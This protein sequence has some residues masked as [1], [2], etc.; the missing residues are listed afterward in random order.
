MH[1]V[2]L[3]LTKKILHPRVLALFFMCSLMPSFCCAETQTLDTFMAPI[4]ENKI[5]KVKEAHPS[6][7]PKDIPIQAQMAFKE[8]I[9]EPGDYPYQR[10]RREAL[11][12]EIITLAP[13]HFPTWFL[14][15]HRESISLAKHKTSG[16]K[17][18]ADAY[19]RFKQRAQK[20]FVTFGEPAQRSLI[21]SCVGKGLNAPDI[22]KEAEKT[23]SLKSIKERT[24]D[25]LRLY[26]HH[27]MPYD[28][29]SYA[30]AQSGQACFKWSHPLK[31][32]MTPEDYREFITVHPHVENLDISANNNTLC[33]KGLKYGE[34]YDV[35]FKQGLP[36]KY[37][38]SLPEAKSFIVNIP[39]RSDMLSFREKGYI[40]S[41]YEKKILPLSLTNLT[42]VEAKLYHIPN[43]NI[44]PVLQSHGGLK[45]QIQYWHENDF[46]NTTGNFVWEGQIDLDND[47]NNIQTIGLPL[48]QMG[49]D[50]EKPGL[51]VLQAHEKDDI[52]H[53]WNKESSTQWFIVT[54]LAMI[55]LKG[56]DGIHVFV[57]SLK[58]ALP[59]H[60][61]EV[62][63]VSR[64]NRILK[65]MRTDK[66]G[67]AHFAN[68]VTRGEGGNTPYLVQASDT[69]NKDFSLALLDKAPIDLTDHGDQGRKPVAGPYDAY[70]FSGR[71]LYRPGE[72]VT[73]VTLLRDEN[74]KAA[75]DI[76]LTFKV[77]R[78]DGLLI[79]EVVHADKGNGA[80]EVSIQT[81]E[82][83]L[84]GLWKVAAYLD[85]QAN[86]IG[87]MSFS[88]SD[89]IPPKIEIFA[90]AD[91]KQYSPE[92]QINL[93]VKAN[94]LF[95][96]P[97]KAL[98]V[99]GN[100]NITINKAPFPQ[101]EN[102]VFGRSTEE[103]LPKLLTIRPATTDLVGGATLTVQLPKMLETTHPLQV[104]TS[105]DV[106]EAGGRPC[107]IKK[108]SPLFHKKAYVGIL[109][110]FKKNEAPYDGEAGF[111]F[112]AVNAEGQLLK[113]RPLTYTLYKEH[114]DFVWYHRGQWQF[115]PYLNRL[116]T[117]ETNVL[118][119]KDK[120]VS[121]SLPI[122]H[123]KYRID[124]TDPLSGERSSYHF[125]SGWRNDTDGENRPDR[126]A[127]TLDKTDQ[128][129][130]S[131]AQVFIKPP[132]Q[133]QL[134]LLSV[135]KT[136][137]VLESSDIPKSGKSV[138]LTIRP[139]QVAQAGSYLLALVI[140]KGDQGEGH[141]TPRAIGMTW[142]QQK[143]PEISIQMT[144]PKEIS[145]AE[146]LEI[147]VQIQQTDKGEKLPF[148]IAYAVD[149]AV[150]SLTNFALPDP[151]EHYFSRK[152]LGYE[153]YDIYGA[154]IH[155][156]GTKPTS[157]KVGGSGAA[158]MRSLSSALAETPLRSE[159][160]MS[161][162]S[163]ITTVDEQGK[164]LL[165][166]D[167][168]P[169]FSGRL[170]IVT[171]AWN[172]A[173][174]GQANTTVLV[175]DDQQ[176]DLHLPRFLTVGDRM[177]ATLRY[178]TTNENAPLTAMLCLS[179]GFSK[180][181]T[182]VCKEQNF[183]KEQAILPIDVE[184]F[185]TGTGQIDVSY[186]LGKRT[187]KKTWALSILPRDETPTHHQFIYLAPGEAKPIPQTLLEPF[188]LTRHTLSAQAMI[189]PDFVSSRRKAL[190]SYPYGCAE[191]NAGRGFALLSRLIQLKSEGRE[192]NKK[193][194]IKTEKEIHQNMMNLLSL[195]DASG[196]FGTWSATSRVN[197]W[198]SDNTIDLLLMLKK[199]GI[200]VP[201]LAMTYAQNWLEK[202]TY[203]D[204]G[205]RG[206][207]AQAYGYYLLAR[208]QKVNT[209][210]LNYFAKIYAGDLRDPAACAF[211]GAA[212]AHQ[213][214]HEKASVWF[215]K[216]I[217]ALDEKMPDTVEE[218]YG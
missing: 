157:F 181:K 28:V 91:K 164:A 109:P 199:E 171:I 54:D 59:L 186:P 182:P 149:D 41:R 53:D 77:Y 134:L 146:K 23:L 52:K 96:T 107:T 130:G 66:T 33:L 88:V 98:A 40:L 198:F 99:H 165:S 121:I 83:S 201:T 138:Q 174:C 4:K 39:N 110:H 27:H 195:Q 158:S 129:A 148:L 21:L 203:Q 215:A 123:G 71:D 60:N 10:E 31:K 209:H 105:I 17:V 49:P 154:L 94:Y 18:S 65:K 12:K 35:T 102:Y 42:Q 111:S 74:A 145:T 63:L 100:A 213:G 200:N 144:A 191:Q 208:N 156:G 126:V 217:K 120:P 184:A 113:D 183:E 2:F 131:P 70:L 192:E 58:T 163:G 143:K 3:F 117:I 22:Q 43:R 7:S 173:H 85:P 89:F 11:F 185:Q 116:E 68:A 150:L 95:G 37:A 104:E 176:V 141:G 210:K 187:K 90:Q 216:A 132:Y 172:H 196:G 159:E 56:K 50:I 64:N 115:E 142:L 78:P 114:Y 19:K 136:V 87:E 61:I 14:W 205:A 103:W 46:K 140:R 93:T 55:S 168:P 122:Q 204:R 86:P 13:C 29:K 25:M 153:Y 106:L 202:M 62:S 188:N 36:G 67:H 151:L 124:I 57:R 189:F 101:W 169:S 20:A 178:H 128:E 6:L 175:K 72:K 47:L 26:P 160:I 108:T 147:P 214:D 75:S 8:N 139:D 162:F 206:L 127:L 119:M 44:V 170:R 76:P 161:I 212:Y 24:D 167:I 207:S 30:E 9:E 34:S 5:S 179:E 82:T 80:Y 193:E 1:K 15:L 84:S 16:R 137:R 45:K 48:D 81:K 38:L 112:I 32:D 69:P 190:L 197:P 135:G 218:T 211:M 152:S 194:I 166:F 97:A 180:D 51:Y 177:H 79:S 155:T 133:G 118:N 125:S 92:E 73:I